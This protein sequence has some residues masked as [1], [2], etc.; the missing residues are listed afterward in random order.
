MA[1]KTIPVGDTATGKWPKVLTDESDQVYDYAIYEEVFSGRWYQPIAAA[2][3]ALGTIVPIFRKRYA[4]GI[5]DPDGITVGAH[6]VETASTIDRI[7]DFWGRTSDSV[8]GFQYCTSTPTAAL[9]DTNGIG[10]NLETATGDM[11]IFIGTG[12][13][14]DADNWE[15]WVEYTRS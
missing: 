3:G 8:T 12:L 2:D 14:T 15:C 5:V 7:I 13:A 6:E 4:K 11:Q 1:S 10:V 9:M